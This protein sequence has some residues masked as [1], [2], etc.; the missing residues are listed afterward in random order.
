MSK[1]VK[2]LIAALIA[3]TASSVVAMVLMI[4]RRPDT[5]DED[6][7]VKAPLRVSVKN[8]RKLITLDQQTQ[9][10]EHIDV[11]APKPTSM[12]A[13]SRG[14]A[15]LLPVN[16]IATLRNNYVAARAK[17]ERA[18][19]DLAL[20][21]SSYE[22]T[23][24]LYEQNQNM[25]LKAL[26][27]AEATYRNNQAQVRAAELDAKVQVD[28]VRQRWGGVV[29][30]WITGD[31]GVL[32]P[33]LEQREFL[34]QV[35][36]PPGEVGKPAATLSLTT[37]GKQFVQARL[38]SS[39]PEVS[40]QIQGISFLYLVPGRPGL[41]VGM[42]LVA[43]VPIGEPLRGMVVPQS[44]I[45]WWQGKAW[46]YEQ[47]SPTTFARREVPTD[48]PVSGGYFVPAANLASETKIVT[49]GAQ[50]LLSEEFRSEIQQQD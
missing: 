12:R 23:K 41:A 2:W 39:F 40:P 37:P 47:L 38:V 19:V 26:Q 35:T 18:G 43:F 8:G 20:S 34:V 33:V 4:A 27:D 30:G 14:T 42:N 25:S 21:K 17:L 45:V 13:E 10:Q 9:T 3:I 31:K 22:R 16:D 36:F 44:A 5:D 15:V 49:V 7:A 28:T 48:N 6:E 50:T 46:M 1:S 32:E 29:A 11:R 24:T